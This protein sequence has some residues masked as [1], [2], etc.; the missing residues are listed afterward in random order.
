MVEKRQFNLY[1]SEDLIKRVKHAA[2]EAEQRLS[3]YVAQA[4]ER[5]LT[6]HGAEHEEDGR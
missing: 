2:I 6:D 3:D 5:Q 4:L 1:L